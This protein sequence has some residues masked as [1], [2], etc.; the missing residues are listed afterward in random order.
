MKPYIKRKKTG[1]TR[2]L[3]KSLLLA[4]LVGIGSFTAC[5]SHNDDS[6]YNRANKASEKALRELDRE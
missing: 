2:L 1:G 4:I 3:H 5:A 6:Y